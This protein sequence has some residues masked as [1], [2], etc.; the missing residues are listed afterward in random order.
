M[1]EGISIADTFV[2]AKYF[3]PERL[4]SILELNKKVKKWY[5]GMKQVIPSWYK[6]YKY[7]R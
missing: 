6:E 2:W 7:S 4:E 5:D 1:F 3:A